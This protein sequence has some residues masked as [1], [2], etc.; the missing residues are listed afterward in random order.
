MRCAF[1]AAADKIH[2]GDRRRGPYIHGGDRT[3]THERNYHCRF[4]NVHKNRSPRI[5]LPP[6]SAAAR[7]SPRPRARRVIEKDGE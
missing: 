1:L 4:E 5:A 7:C 2:Q 3:A 6:N